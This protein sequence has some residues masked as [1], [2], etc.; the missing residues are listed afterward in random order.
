ME[1]FTNTHL[2]LLNANGD[3]HDLPNK[4]SSTFI[5]N[6]E[7]NGGVNA[8]GQSKKGFMTKTQLMPQLLPEVVLKG[9]LDTDSSRSGERVVVEE[10]VPISKHTP[11]SE[12]IG[13]CIHHSAKQQGTT[14]ITRSSPR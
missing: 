11:F 6:D 2:N 14:K 3:I 7:I 10:F 8:F 5:I 9:N 4:Q 12:G 13:H 1:K